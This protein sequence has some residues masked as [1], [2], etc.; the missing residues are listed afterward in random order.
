M[1]S[2][3]AQLRLDVQGRVDVSAHVAG[4]DGPPGASTSSNLATPEGEEKKRFPLSQE[5]HEP[6]SLA[7]AQTTGGRSMQRL[8]VARAPA[9]LEK[10]RL[11]GNLTRWIC[12]RNWWR[13]INSSLSAPDQE[14][15]D[16]A[17]S[18]Q[19]LMAPDLRPGL[20]CAG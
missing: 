18:W 6:H 1:C 19:N 3:E 13:R 10:H 12:S 9:G 20:G 2:G 15:L 11:Q 5:I 4:A 7:D 16:V 8:D 17:G 14:Q